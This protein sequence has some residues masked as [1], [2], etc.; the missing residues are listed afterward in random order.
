M[1]NFNAKEIERQA[2]RLAEETTN[3]QSNFN[4]GR[5]LCENIANMVKSED[6]NLAGAWQK[7]AGVYESLS[8][9]YSSALDTM[10]TRMKTYAAKTVVNEEVV[11]KVVHG[12]GDKLEDVSS[13]L[14]NIDL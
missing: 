1:A 13:W 12:V 6:S 2:T 11:E 7:L 9:K 14:Q 10:N 3:I 8:A 5:S 4:I